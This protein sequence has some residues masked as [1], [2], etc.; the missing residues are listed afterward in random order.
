HYN[1]H[2]GEPRLYEDIT[3]DHI[4]VARQREADGKP[5]KSSRP[6][7]ERTESKLTREEIAAGLRPWWE[8]WRKHNPFFWIQDGVTV[9]NLTVSNVARRE[10][11]PGTQ[12]LFTIEKNARVRNLKL[13]DVLQV[14]N[15][16]KPLSLIKNSGTVERLSL[17]HVILRDRSG[18]DAIQPIIG[19]GT[20]S[21]TTGAFITEGN[22]Q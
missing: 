5:E 21:E 1:V 12:P 2:R 13:R 18:K 16:G 11:L 6:T 8:D 15:T 20:V 17:D 3:L 19:N 22:G 9:D 4:Y 14:N 10:W 7:G